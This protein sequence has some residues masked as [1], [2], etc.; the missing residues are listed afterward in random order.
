MVH[1]ARA[2]APPCGTVTLSSHMRSCTP[3]L[4]SASALA[5]QPI[6]VSAARDD[7]ARRAS[8]LAS[9]LCPLLL[10]GLGAAQPVTLPAAQTVQPPFPPLFSNSVTFVPGTAARSQLAFDVND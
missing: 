10:A 2:L 8:R 3:A 9:S 4:V 1:R 7:R 5:A 6:V